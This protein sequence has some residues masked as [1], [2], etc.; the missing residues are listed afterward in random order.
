MLGLAVT[1][2]AFRATMDPWFP[3]IGGRWDV[4]F[5]FT[6]YLGQRRT[7]LEGGALALFSA[8]LYTLSSVAPA[9][10]FI[11]QYFLLF[12][13]ARLASY[14]IYANRMAS[15]I[16]LLLVLS[17]ANRVML[18]LI[19]AGFGHSLYAFSAPRE[20]I[21]FL[22]VNTVTGFFLYLTMNLI[23]RATFKVPR[24]NIELKEAE[25]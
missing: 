14:T 3:V 25:L 12:V 15:I 11:I 20:L 16:S 4:L 13:I 24:I 19:S 1:L 8:H 22:V 7:W 21:A 2:L 5:A 10:V 23:D 18:Q 17:L 9:G 6:V